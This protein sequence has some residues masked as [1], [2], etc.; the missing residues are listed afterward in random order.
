M[1]HSDELLLTFYGDDFTGSTDAMESLARAGVRTIL[2]LEPPT[3]EMNLLITL[4]ASV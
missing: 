3:A 2:F 4:G 1:S